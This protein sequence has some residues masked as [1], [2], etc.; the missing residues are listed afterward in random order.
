MNKQAKRT[1]LAGAIFLLFTLLLLFFFFMLLF[2]STPLQRAAADALVFSAKVLVPALFPFA[3]LSRFLLLSGLLPTKGKFVRS[4]AR[5]FHL[6]PETLPAF[7][8]GLFC[9][10][11]MGA[12]AAASL[13]ESGGIGKEEAYRTASVANNASAAFLLISAGALFGSPLCGRILFISQTAASLTVA[14]F[15]ARRAKKNSP[16]Q[17]K[18]LTP[19]ERAPL[20]LMPLAADAIVKAGTAMLSVTAFVVFFSVI[21]EAVSQIPALLPLTPLILSFLEATSAVKM[22]AGLVGSLGLPLALSLAAFA[23][24]FSGLSVLMQSQACFDG[25]LPLT[26]L[27][28]CRAAIAALSALFALLLSLAFGL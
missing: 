5:L 17:N 28:T 9:G 1:P 20:P 12:F 23:V 7:A 14:L 3:V 18:T 8:V 19:K 2:R 10:F 11:P 6:S 26:P 22:A 13:L 16:P 21:A 24:G 15:W 27:V 4:V 25:K